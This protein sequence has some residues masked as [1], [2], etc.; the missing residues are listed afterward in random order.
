MSHGG[1]KKEILKE[2]EE[3][4]SQFNDWE[5]TDKEDL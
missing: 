3:I 5:C 2:I 1:K 4:E